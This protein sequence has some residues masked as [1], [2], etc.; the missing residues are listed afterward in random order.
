MRKLLVCIVLLLAGSAVAE[1][2]DIQSVQSVDELI[3]RLKQTQVA[4]DKIQSEREAEFIKRRDQQSRLLADAKA[5]LAR[6][7]SENAR[8]LK[9]NEAAERALRDLEEK[10]RLKAGGIDEIHGHV[11]QAAEE[12]S[13]SLRNGANA[14]V[15]LNE[16]KTAEDVESSKVLPSIAQIESLWVAMLSEMAVSSKVV[17]KQVEVIEADGLRNTREVLFNGPFSAISARQLLRYLPS[18]RLLSLPQEQP[19][20]WYTSSV[21]DS[22]ADLSSGEIV[23]LLIDPSR[24]ALLDTLVSRPG[25]VDRI[26]QGGWIGYLILLLGL[27][28][29]VV[30]LLRLREL[31]GVLRQ[32][33]SQLRN[34]SE[35]DAVNPLG[36]LII[37][38]SNYRSA[39]IQS[40]ELKLDEAILR[41]TAGLERGQALLRLFSASA[42]LLGLLGT[43]VGMIATFQSITIVGS[44]DPRYMA[45]GISQALVTTMLGLCVAVPLLFLNSLL[46]ARSREVS[47]VLEQESVGLIAASFEQEENS[48]W[49]KRS[50]AL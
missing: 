31:S 3:K 13:S 19:A 29:L 24:G 26:H 18:E 25:V 14:A 42:P 45:G 8:L 6:L 12:F 49:S 10:V 2:P 7:E 28:G 34:I 32:V 11:R 17:A 1:E 40:L 50:A 46:Q 30:G 47:E 43:V 33:R 4:E 22:S 27:V 38:Y 9:R 37:V 39:D 36:R 21:A 23:Q 48:E 16:I 20:N 44:G 15:L 35:P 5:E 41:E